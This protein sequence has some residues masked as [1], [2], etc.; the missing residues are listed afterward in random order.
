L[1]QTSQA[2]CS[3]LHD[4]L[5]TLRWEVAAARGHSSDA[6]LERRQYATEVNKLRYELDE[7]KRKLEANLSAWDQEREQFRLTMSG[8]SL[9]LRNE[10]HA[11]RVL[12]RRWVVGNPSAPAISTRVHGGSSGE[13]LPINYEVIRNEGMVQELAQLREERAQLSA[14]V[15]ELE[16][17]AGAA[18]ELEKLRQDIRAMHVERQLL[19]RRLADAESRT[20]EHETLERQFEELQ[21]QLREMDALKAE[22]DRLRARL[23][24]TPTSSGTF[25]IGSRVTAIAAGIIPSTDLVSELEDLAHYFEARSAVV[26]DGLGFPVATVGS[27]ADCEHLAAVAGEADRLASHAKQILGL[28]EVTQLTLE[29]RQGTIAHFR[30]FAIDDNIMSVGTLGTLVPQRE[31]LDRVVALTKQTLTTPRNNTDVSG[32]M[33]REGSAESAMPRTDVAPTMG[34]G[35]Q[36]KTGTRK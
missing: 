18:H 34:I 8:L 3:K 32:D 31:E 30:Y 1:Q 22:T 17:E 4:E 33:H 21:L 6:T 36:R 7:T 29:D 13:L 28:T 10:H 12:E 2:E 23:Y 26:A 25:P 20:L 35:G 27:N 11:A 24:N 16:R 9:E 5:E 15:R 14:R 19:E